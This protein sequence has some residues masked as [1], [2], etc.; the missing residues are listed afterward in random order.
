M[1]GCRLHLS[2]QYRQKWRVGSSEWSEGHTGPHKMRLIVL[3]T[4][5]LLASLIGLLFDGLSYLMRP[6]AGVVMLKIHTAEFLVR[7]ILW[8]QKFFPL[9]TTASH[10]SL[11]LDKLTH[12]MPSI[13]FKKEFILFSH[14]HLGLPKSPLLYASSPKYCTHFSAWLQV[15]HAISI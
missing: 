3:Q 9:F 11:Y 7:S 12:S 2:V 14:S 13:S 5:D 4:Q 10:M 1:G 15:R 6:E 8:I